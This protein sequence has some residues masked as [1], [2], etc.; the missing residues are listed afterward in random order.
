MEAERS[1]QTILPFLPINVQASVLQRIPLPCAGIG[2][3]V[4]RGLLETDIELLGGGFPSVAIRG[5]P[6]HLD[7]DWAALRRSIGR[8]L[9]AHLWR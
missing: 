9:T 4:L 8:R 5:G 1:A 3:R 6:C 7:S 2:G